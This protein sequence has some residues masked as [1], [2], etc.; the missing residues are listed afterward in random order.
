MRNIII[1]FFAV[2]LLLN[3]PLWAD[4]QT[5]TATATGIWTDW[6]VVNG[7]G[8][9]PKADAVQS[10]D[11]AGSYIVN[12]FDYFGTGGR[13]SFELSNMDFRASIDSVV[14]RVKAAKTGANPNTQT[15]RIGII[16]GTSV[17]WSG[18]IALSTTY[19]L[20]S[21]VFTTDPNTGG[22]WTVDAVQLAEWADT[23][24]A[25]QSASGKHQDVSYIEVLVYSPETPP[26][27]AHDPLQPAYPCGA[28][29]GDT[30][31]PCAAGFAQNLTSSC[32]AGNNWQ[33]VDDIPTSTGC[34][35]TDSNYTTST[36]MTF[37]YYKLGIKPDSTKRWGR[38]VG[39]KTLNT[40]V[41]GIAV[42]GC[43]KNSASGKSSTVRLGLRDTTGHTML[44][45]PFTITSAA[46]GTQVVSWIFP[47]TLIGA[48]FGNT[49]WDSVSMLGLQ[50]A[51]GL[52]RAGGTSYT[53]SI[54][55]LFAIVYHSERDTTI[56]DSTSADLQVVACS[57]SATLNSKY[58]YLGFQS[59]ANQQKMWVGVTSSTGTFLD[60]GKIISASQDT[61]R[62]WLWLDSASTGDNTDN[63]QQ[64]VPDS[65]TIRKAPDG[66]GSNTYG[67]GFVLF[68]DRTSGMADSFNI[69]VQAITVVD[70]PIFYQ[71][72]SPSQTFSDLTSRKD[73]AI[74]IK[75]APL[76]QPAFHSLGDTTWVFGSTGSSSTGQFRWWRHV[77]GVIK[78]SGYIRG[79]GATYLPGDSIKRDSV[80]STSGF[81][82]IAI[83]RLSG[84]YPGIVMEG[85][86]QNTNT[87]WFMKWHPEVT[88]AD[89]L[90]NHAF[91]RKDGT[92]TCDTIAITGQ[93]ISSSGQ[94]VAT[95]IWR[96]SDT[97]VHLA[98][99]VQPRI[100]HATINKSLTVTRDT[101]FENPT[102]SSTITLSIA[103]KDT[104][105]Y[106]F[107][108]IAKTTSPTD[109]TYLA[110][111]LWD[112]N[113]GHFRSP[114]PVIFDMSQQVQYS[115]AATAQ[116]QYGNSAIGFSRG[117]GRAGTAYK[118]L[119][120]S[121]IIRTGN[122]AAAGGGAPSPLRRRRLIIEKN[123]RVGEKDEKDDSLAIPVFSG[124]RRTWDEER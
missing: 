97:L 100:Y 59:Y 93:P 122:Y 90:R 44:S 60:S 50:A 111:Q 61:G 1:K 16:S 65:I 124:L 20:Y 73:S 67:S 8:A 116:Y 39:T 54:N 70:T 2:F 18:N 113:C 89:S 102:G 69:G 45:P 92:S 12:G 68:G 38:D 24:V 120:A 109:T 78:D 51:V 53:F 84:G 41:D 72:A 34:A 87:I 28:T 119:W 26:G 115:F 36:T 103:A 94:L 110:Y 30:L 14:V 11:G 86:T 117:S 57:T 9:D 82:G 13:Q 99:Y 3:V 48:F 22:A 21:Q 29:T 96:A 108:T 105:V 114:R 15:I 33:C 43:F 5:L 35:G 101:V 27:G 123:Y 66:T 46:G 77:N 112:S 106:L 88:N 17:G 19:T 74:E 23:T 40:Q 80:N 85:W 81:R 79:T 95:S 104:F 118:K 55:N 58:P 75:E 47:D 52:Q 76:Y 121:R 42:A 91:L 25:F 64:G 31:Y 10:D 6:D 71:A 63:W 56:A 32:G 4:T 49:R 7:T 62:T 83:V 98:W 37:D 107:H